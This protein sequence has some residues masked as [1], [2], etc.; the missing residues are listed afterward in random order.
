[1][2]TVL[3][4]YMERI[5]QPDKKTCVIMGVLLLVG[6]LLWALSFA[7]G[8]WREDNLLKKYGQDPERKQFADWIV[9]DKQDLAG[10]PARS[11]L[12]GATMD[13]GL[14]WYNLREFDLAA[15]WWR[16]GLAVEPNNDI[17]WYNLG[18]AYLEMKDYGDSESAYLKSMDYAT[19][20]ETEGCIA[21]GELYRYAYTAKRDQEDDLYLKCLKK[22][23]KNRDIIAR[24]AVYYRD[25][26]DKKNAIKYFDQLFSLDPNAQVAEEIRKL[27]Q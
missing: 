5:S 22:H 17:G 3:N 13:I 8:M 16:K 27:S 19:E 11:Q 9:K 12:I 10:N 4:R 14:Q 25:A 26:G 24:L 6:I 15:K 23:P 7:Y 21:L 20:G 18:N 2:K 1:M